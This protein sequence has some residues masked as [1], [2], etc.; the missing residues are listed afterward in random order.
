M[1]FWPSY[2]IIPFHLNDLLA[3]C[4]ASSSPS[5]GFQL[6]SIVRPWSST[7]LCKPF[8]PICSITSDEVD[9]LLIPFSSTMSRQR[10]SPATLLEPQ[11]WI[12]ILLCY[13]SS[14]SGNIHPGFWHNILTNILSFI[15]HN[16]EAASTWSLLRIPNSPRSLPRWIPFLCFPQVPQI[17]CTISSIPYG[18]IGFWTK[19]QDPYTIPSSAY[20]VCLLAQHTEDISIALNC[21]YCILR[22]SKPSPF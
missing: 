18:N 11:T 16:D 17:P 21:R 1:Q 12:L 3:T 20:L 22:S 7:V 14:F 13:Y 9:S 15:T 8:S 4:E 10:T 6:N 5:L 2:L 19:C